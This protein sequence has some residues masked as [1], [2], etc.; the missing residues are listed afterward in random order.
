MWLWLHWPLRLLCPAAAAVSVA[1]V[2]AVGVFAVAAA[3]AVAAVAAVAVATARA[4]VAVPVVCRVAF[5]GQLFR[6]CCVFVNGRLFL[7]WLPVL[8]VE[9]FWLPAAACCCCGSL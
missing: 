8:P 9:F 7:Q 2:P 4:V 5:W 1:A 3:A 6:C